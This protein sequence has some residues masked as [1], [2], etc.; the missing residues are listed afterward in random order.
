VVSQPDGTHG[1]VL[2]Y[3]LGKNLGDG[4]FKHKHVLI[5][6]FFYLDFI[7]FD[8]DIDDL[9]AT[10]P[11]FDSHQVESSIY[12]AINCH[13]FAWALASDSVVTKISP[14]INCKEKS[15]KSTLLSSS[16][17]LHEVAMLQ[18]LKPRR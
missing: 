11:P 5:H 13:K 17:S 12:G 2:Q 7:G 1:G 10:L 9:S 18:Q 3:D 8:P 6:E 14:S 4:V 15:S 16:G